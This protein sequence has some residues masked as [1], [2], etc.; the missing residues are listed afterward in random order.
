MSSAEERTEEYVYEAFASYATDPDAELVRALES[1]VEGF[2]RRNGLPAEMRQEIELCVDGRDFAFPRRIRGRDDFGGIFEI[3]ASYM[4]KSRALLVLTGPLSKDHPWINKE[5]EWWLAN[6]P[7][8]PIYF[9]LTHGRSPDPA[10]SYPPA[11]RDRG[12]D[13]L[14]ISFDLRKFH[15]SAFWRRLVPSFALQERT[16][17]LRKSL[18]EGWQSVR[19]FEEE[20]ARVAARLLADK[21]GGQIALD[22]IEAAWQRQEIR[23]RRT[24]RIW[25]VVGAVTA[26]AV[27]AALWRAGED[28]RTAEKTATS[29]SWLRHARA[30]ADRGGTAL[31]D[32][33]AYAGSA[34]VTRPDAEAS[35]VAM[36]AMQSMVRIVRTFKLDGG[37]PTW[38]A[39]PIES[40]EVA[41]VGGRS[42]ILRALDLKDGKVLWRSDL[43]SSAIRT[44]AFDRTSSA[45]FVG[46]DRGILKLRWKG[47]EQAEGPSEIARALTGSRIGGLAVDPQRKKVVVGL[48]SSGQLL[49]FPLNDE[50]PWK[51]D[52][53]NRIMDPRFVEDGSSEVPSGIYGMNIKGDRLVVVGIDGVVSQLSPDSLA[54]PPRQFVHQQA[55]FAMAVSSDGR[56]LILADEYGGVSV[57]DLETTKLARAT[58]GAPTTASVAKSLQGPF[59]VGIAD[60][61]A[62]VGLAL[63]RED[64]VLAVTS[65]DKTVRFLSYSD[66]APLGTAAHGSAT[67][68][69]AFV[70]STGRALTFSDDGSVQLVEAASYPEVVRLAA[71]G[72]FAVG[73]T[74]LVAWPMRRPGKAG[75]SDPKKESK[76]TEVYSIPLE[77]SQPRSIGKVDDNPGSGLV[78]SPNIVALRP[79]TSTKV[80]LLGVAKRALGCSLLQHLNVENA[81]DVVRQVAAGPE[82]GTLVTLAE[83]HNAPSKALFLSMWN[84]QDCSIVRSLETI[85]PFAIATDAVVTLPKAGVVEVRTP[86][87]AEPLTLNF[88]RDI[89]QVGVSDKASTLLVTLQNPAGICVC[90]RTRFPRGRRDS[91]CAAQS[92]SY[93]CLPVEQSQQAGSASLS[94]SGKYSIAKAKSGAQML[95]SKAAGWRYDEV[96]PAP[97]RSLT[98]PFA[99]DAAEKRL[100]VPAG[101]TGVSVLDPANGRRLL[102]FPTPNQ[103]TDI[104][105]LG[106]DRLV[107][108]DGNVLRVWDLGLS[109]L[110]K[111]LCD[112]WNSELPIDSYPGI[113]PALAREKIC[114]R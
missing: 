17:E 21:S 26:V 79:M 25:Q 14:P 30:L 53:V 100:A 69:V 58:S 59:A 99:F 23:D 96:A 88:G 87:S 11:L 32:A 41:L 57:Y 75:F 33:L 16:L 52:V 114:S 110:Q 101:Q 1:V 49:S 27:A 85:G 67:R 108:L 89:V 42:G 20:S 61:Y 51:G 78:V 77:G 38:T 55:V 7:D 40:E 105:F 47:R 80:S 111:S 22:T 107:T 92:K 74:E 45:I 106:T 97:M 82:K 15:W 65:H 91:R 28:V 104:A 44:I 68:A 35:G 9:C 34:L 29:Q 10:K 46:T 31:P 19:P 90:S 86:P 18:A 63:D 62:T 109:A 113:P 12:W 81:V 5:V 95:A 72:G 98:S 71:V 103:V 24:R 73:E 4:R 39:E 76:A 112:R 70:G 50:L 2:H 93:G 8:D 60:R 56:E 94:A 66:L 43:R 6:R 84:V 64:R 37:D 102:E 3:V 83:R 36:T 54:E 13:D 48:L